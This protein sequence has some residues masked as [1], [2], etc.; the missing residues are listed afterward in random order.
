[1]AYALTVIEVPAWAFLEELN[2]HSN[3]FWMLKATVPIS[4]AEPSISAAMTPSTG[5]HA[6]RVRG[7]PGLRLASHF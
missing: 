3:S 1:M 2:S 4:T 5:P 7:S 6:V